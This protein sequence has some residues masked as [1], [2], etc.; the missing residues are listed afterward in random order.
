MRLPP[1]TDPEL[2]PFLREGL[3][4]AK[5][6]T[7]NPDGT[8]RMTPLTYAVGEDDEIIFSTWQDSTAARNL[9]R[10]PQASVLIDKVDQPYAGVH[11]I[12]TADAGK[13]SLTPQ[14]YAQLFGRYIGDVEQ[15]ARSYEMMN[16]LGLGPRYSIRFRPRS[17]VTW[18]FGKIPRG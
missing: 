3:W 11:Y 7:H 10:N 5:I 2:A 17:K 9:Q 12:G 4:I 6:A 1:L 15:A 16:S 18:D 14:Q 8:I 13:E